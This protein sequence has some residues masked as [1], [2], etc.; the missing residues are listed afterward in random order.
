MRWQYQIKAVPPLDPLPLTHDGWLGSYPDYL[1]RIRLAIAAF[2][3]AVSPIEPIPNVSTDMGWDGRQPAF[4]S[5]RL[6]PQLGDWETGA[7]PPVIVFTDR[8]WAPDYP[9]RPDRRL[10]GADLQQAAAFDPFPRTAATSLSAWAIHP[11]RLVRAHLSPAHLPYMTVGP[12]VPIPN[13]RIPIED[14]VL[15]GQN[16]SIE[17]PAYPSIGG[18]ITW[19]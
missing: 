10:I 2:P 18:S 3:E 16:Q 11:D 15:L 12:L 7:F 8:S 6:L 4:L 13:A 19:S 17:T 14:R 9:D 1:R 5:R